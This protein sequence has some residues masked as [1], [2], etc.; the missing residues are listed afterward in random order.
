MSEEWKTLDQAAKD[1]YQAVSDR[2]K[3]KYVKDK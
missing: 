2:A 3:E 1:R